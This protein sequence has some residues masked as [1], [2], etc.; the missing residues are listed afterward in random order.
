MNECCDM[1][2]CYS[3]KMPEELEARIPMFS[4]LLDTFLEEC[5]DVENNF[6]LLHLGLL[7]IFRAVKAKNKEETLE[8]FNQV[9]GIMNYH[10]MHEYAVLN[11]EIIISLLLFS[12]DPEIIDQGRLFEMRKR[13]SSMVKIV[14]DESTR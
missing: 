2:L 3:A 1:L 14:E 4:S 6:S 12:L 7:K 13:F 9:I 8:L 10:D 5:E 11:F